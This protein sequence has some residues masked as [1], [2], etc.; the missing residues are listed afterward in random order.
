MF[1]RDLAG[2]TPRVVHVEMF[3][4]HGATIAVDGDL[5]LATAPQLQSA[6][7]EMISYGHRHLVIDLAEATFMD[8]TGMQSLLTSLAPLRDEP[9]ARVVLAGVHGIVER[10][11]A[12]SGVAS[13]FTAFDTREAAISSLGDAS[14]ELSDS[15]RHLQDRPQ[16]SL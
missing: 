12:I 2:R 11:L 10:T 8:S 9:G 15:W 7:D 1:I 5:D 16:L 14:D 6:I 4:D 3:D 13:L